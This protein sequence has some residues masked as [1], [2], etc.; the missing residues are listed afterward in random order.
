M[1]EYKGPA[2]CSLS[3]LLFY[4][5]NRGTSNLHQGKR[6]RP[7]LLIAQVVRYTSGHPVFSKKEFT[8]HALR[9]DRST[10]LLIHIAIAP[11]HSHFPTSNLISNLTEM[12]FSANAYAYALYCCKSSGVVSSA[13]T[14][15]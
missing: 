12:I 8:D 2:I 6:K 7:L 1:Q 13:L 11:K 14:S 4:W 10:G 5:V 9:L 15:W 3:P